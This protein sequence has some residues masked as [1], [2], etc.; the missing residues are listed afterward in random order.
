MDDLL[1]DEYFGRKWRLG[2]WLALGWLFAE[3]LVEF[4][5]RNPA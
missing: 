1:L 3:L 4:D 2:Y 5:V